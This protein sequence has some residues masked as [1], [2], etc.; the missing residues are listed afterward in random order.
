MV[1]LGK[2]G[3]SSSRTWPMFIRPR[4]VPDSGR[5]ANA[6]DALVPGEEHE[7]VLADLY[8]VAVGQLHFLDPVAVDVGAVEAAD[9]TDRE[10]VTRAV[11][12]RMPTR[13]RDIV[14]EDLAVR[15]PAGVDDVLV[16]QEPAARA[17][18]LL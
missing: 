12:D 18:T 10:L 11:E 9:V 3:R 6:L 2:S 13:H 1:T 17:R 16:E 7:P 8:F 4:V 15:V 14:E 5:L